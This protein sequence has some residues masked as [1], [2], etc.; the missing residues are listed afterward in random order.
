MLTSFVILLRRV[1]FKVTLY[2]CVKMPYLNPTTPNIPSVKVVELMAPAL[3]GLRLRLIGLPDPVWINVTENCIENMVTNTT[4][5]SWGCGALQSS[6]IKSDPGAVAIWDGC[7]KTRMG[8]INIPF[9]IEPD[10]C[11]ILPFVVVPGDYEPA[12][13]GTAF[14][15]SHHASIKY[16]TMGRRSVSFCML[17][18][19]GRVLISEYCM[20]T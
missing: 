10:A 13:I 6:F 19:Q 17:N 9:W 7:I 18:E 15:E 16:D 14:L 5:E 12:R 2:Y 11:L 8:E 20:M 4:L 3:I 1:Y